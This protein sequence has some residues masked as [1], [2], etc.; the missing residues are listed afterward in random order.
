MCFSE[1][2]ISDETT[3]VLLAQINP[4]VIREPEYLSVIQFIHTEFALKD[5]I[6]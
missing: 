4:H 5:Y 1:R 2:A 6:R 3:V